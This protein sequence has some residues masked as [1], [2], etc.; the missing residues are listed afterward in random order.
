MKL[1]QLLV[2]SSD[3]APLLRFYK[4]AE[5]GLNPEFEDVLESALIL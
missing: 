1:I 3:Y 2:E 4:A 5:R